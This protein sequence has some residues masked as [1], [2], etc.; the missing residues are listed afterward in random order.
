[1]SNLFSHNKYKKL[2][3][4]NIEDYVFGRN[5]FFSEVKIA[6]YLCPRSCGK[7]KNNLVNYH[8]LRDLT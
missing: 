5:N 3:I 7:L 2:Y 6:S 1:M 8:G 4:P